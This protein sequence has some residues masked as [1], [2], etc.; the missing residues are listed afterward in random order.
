MSRTAADTKKFPKIE[1]SWTK[2]TPALVRA[3]KEDA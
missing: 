2:P 1:I 3:M